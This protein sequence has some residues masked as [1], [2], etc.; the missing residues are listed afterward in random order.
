[1]LVPL[2]NIAAIAALA[3]KRGKGV[4]LAIARNPL[5]VACVA[6]LGWNALAIP[7]PGVVAKVLEHLAGAALPLGLV[8]A[9]A[10]LEFVAGTLPPRAI[11]WWH[12]I[13]LGALPALAYVLAP[14]CGLSLVERQVAVL[15]AAV[16]TAPSSYILAMQMNGTGAPVAL[17]ISTG[18]LLAI[19][20]LPLWL[21]LVG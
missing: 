20:T 9:G 1:V 19:V 12:L 11:A 17:L 7:L 6:G 2:V 18:T 8:A 4:W 21:A 3:P 15:L 16:P 10:G 5:V 13:K 14:V